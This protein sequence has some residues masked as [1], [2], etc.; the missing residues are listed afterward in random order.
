MKQLKYPR[1]LSQRISEQPVGKEILVYDE[2][3]HEA[4]CLNPVSAAVWRMSDGTHSVAQIA[5][6]ATLDLAHPVGK[7]MVTLALE[8]LR[9]HS[10][11]EAPGSEEFVIDVSR[12]SL[13]QNL[14][15]GATLMLP[16]VAMIAAPTAAQAYSGGVFSPERRARRRRLESAPP[17]D[18]NDPFAPANPTPPSSW[19]SAPDSN[20]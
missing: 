10:L 19:G 12:R 3:R 20:R 7:E 14:G 13:L 16:V 5:E 11:L 6:L 15:A 1:R 17:P 9:R 2:V 18:S 4:F 8:E